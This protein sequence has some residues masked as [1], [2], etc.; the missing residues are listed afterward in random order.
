MVD[1]VC[2]K[3][4]I[5]IYVLIFRIVGFDFKVVLLDVGQYRRGRG[6]SERIIGTVYLLFYMFFMRMCYGGRLYIYRG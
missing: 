5:Y 1:V 2:R 4:V 3:F 6:G